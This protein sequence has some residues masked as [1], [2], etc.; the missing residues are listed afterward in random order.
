MYNWHSGSRDLTA[1]SCQ[2]QG[3]C[4]QREEKKK[5]ISR[6]ELTDHTRNKNLENQYFT[7]KYRAHINTKAKTSL[8]C[9]SVREKFA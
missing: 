5:N 8:D 3:D 2:S 6:C 1:S 7:L 4:E 9:S